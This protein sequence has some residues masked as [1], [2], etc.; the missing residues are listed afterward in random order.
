MKKLLLAGVLCALPILSHAKTTVNVSDFDGTVTVSTT[1]TWVECPK[2][3]LT[4]P[5]VGYS[6]SKNLPDNVA[7]AVEISDFYTNQYYGMNTLRLNIDGEIISLNKLVPH[8]PTTFSRLDLTNSTQ[9]IDFFEIP[10][11]KLKEF[12]QAESI[13]MQLVTDK[14]IFDMVYKGGK[15]QTKA[16]KSL[17]EFLN[18]VEKSSQ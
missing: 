1:A 17:D 8:K 12:N 6:W 10:M 2:S 11:D 5:L 9:S 13:K 16:H 7:L 4:C 14:Q 18:T 3:K 15:K